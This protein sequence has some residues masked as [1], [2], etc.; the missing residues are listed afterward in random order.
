MENEINNAIP[1]IEG[2]KREID[3]LFNTLLEIE[4]KN[5]PIKLQKMKDWFKEINEFSLRKIINEEDIFIN[6]REIRE[7]FK[8]QN[9][10]LK[11]LEELE[12]L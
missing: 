12:E 11:E 7:F 5:S 9:L 2:N 3:C 1:H 8:K 4:Y 10:K 6:F